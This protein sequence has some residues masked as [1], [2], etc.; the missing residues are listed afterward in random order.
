M[1]TN[2]TMQTSYVESNH[3]YS[4]EV[5]LWCK[6]FNNLMKAEKYAAIAVV[7]YYLPHQCTMVG[8]PLGDLEY[9]KIGESMRDNPAMF[10]AA[11]RTGLLAEG[12]DAFCDAA[13]DNAESWSCYADDIEYL[14]TN[15]ELCKYVSFSDRYLAESFLAGGNMLR[16]VENEDVWVRYSRAARKKLDERQTRGNAY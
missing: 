10:A 5:D 9:K 2:F 8:C 11:E 16:E 14:L 1:Y 4:A 13:L 15:D 6:N 3:D 12:I 7:A